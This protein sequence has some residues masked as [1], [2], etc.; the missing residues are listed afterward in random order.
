MAGAGHHC[1]GSSAVCPR[2][3]WAPYCLTPKYVC[4]VLSLF[5]RPYVTKPRSVPYSAYQPNARQTVGFATMSCLLPVDLLVSTVE[6]GNKTKLPRGPTAPA[7]CCPGSL[8]LNSTCV[9]VTC[10]QMAKACSM[11]TTRQQTVNMATTEHEEAPCR[12]RI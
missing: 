11:S 9:Q 7:R 6:P 12:P 1:H 3:S 10:R 4:S 5:G 2:L 8:V